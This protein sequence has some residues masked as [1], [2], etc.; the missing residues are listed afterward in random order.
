[1]YIIYEVIIYLLILNDTQLLAIK[2]SLSPGCTQT[3][4]LE[5]DTDSQRILSGAYTIIYLECND[6]SHHGRL[7][8]LIIHSN[9]VL[10]YFI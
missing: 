9:V 6:S 10:M 5:L 1:M 8:S 3:C 4:L 7:E 2:V